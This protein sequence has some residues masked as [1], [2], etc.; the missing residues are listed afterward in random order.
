MSSQASP[1]PIR[2]VNAIGSHP[3]RQADAQCCRRQPPGPMSRV[4]SIEY[5]NPGLGE[6]NG[7]Y[8]PFA[9]AALHALPRKLADVEPTGGVR[10]SQA[11]RERCLS[12]RRS[13][14]AA[15]GEEAWAH[16]CQR[17]QK[18]MG[19]VVRCVRAFLLAMR[20]DEWRGCQRPPVRI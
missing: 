4:D 6:A 10:T 12:G 5:V 7:G 13:V 16:P 8:H 15:A 3:R 14:R 1:P 19:A 9:A 2:L 11:A 17:M 20:N 18:D